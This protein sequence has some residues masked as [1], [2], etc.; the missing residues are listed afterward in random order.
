MWSPA[1][2]VLACAGRTGDAIEEEAESLFERY[3]NR[4][5]GLKARFPA[6]TFVHVTLPVIRLDMGLKRLAKRLLG[7]PTGEQA[8]IALT[9][10]NELLR[11]HYAG[12]EPVF[13]LAAVEST[14]ANG[15][16]F[17]GTERGR[18]FEALRPD[19]TDDG[20]HLNAVGG[21]AAAAALLAML[22]GLQGG[23]ESGR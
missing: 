10:Y 23:G 17:A 19:L 15:S 2:S 21:R 6:T 20:E 9:R 14:M 5:A 11:A 7:R 18:A 3:R 13:D 8:N 22:S 4:M 16:R 1:E 12:S